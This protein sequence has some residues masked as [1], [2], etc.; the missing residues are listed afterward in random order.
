MTTPESA[1]QRLT[2]R[3]PGML[4]LAPVALVFAIL[5]GTLFLN[6]W[7]A[8][9]DTGAPSPVL[10][11]DEDGQCRYVSP[12]CVQLLSAFT[13]WSADDAAVVTT[14]DISVYAVEPSGDTA[15]TE[16]LILLPS[17]PPRA[18]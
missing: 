14:P 7:T 5:A 16:A 13:V 11:V 10:M 15:P 9:G 18:A 2:Q 8:R 17:P 1:S 6:D 12:S 3:A 4:A